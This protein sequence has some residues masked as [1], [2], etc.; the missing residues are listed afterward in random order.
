MKV[1]VRISLWICL[2]LLAVFLIQFAMHFGAPANESRTG[3]KIR[4]TY[5]DMRQIAT[6][7]E[8]YRVELGAYP[9]WALGENS[10]NGSHQLPS[11]S[12]EWARYFT[13]LPSSIG[14]TSGYLPNGLFRDPF[15]KGDKTFSYYSANDSWII[16]GLGPDRKPDIFFD[17][18][19]DKDLA[20][21]ATFNEMQHHVYTGTNGT[22]SAGDIFRMSEK[23]FSPKKE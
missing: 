12:T 11:F 2:G 6:A 22:R 21:F 4:A 14:F 7:L 15:A 20:S 16:W 3:R 8:A 5:A 9:P 19:K 18:I 1:L 17:T 23:V 10:I 13:R